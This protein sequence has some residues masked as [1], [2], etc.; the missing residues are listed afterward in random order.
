MTF[1]RIVLPY[2]FF[3]GVRDAM[4]CRASEVICEGP[5]DCLGGETRIFVV[6]RGPVP[7]EAL[8]QENRSVTV[9]S[10]DGPAIAEAPFIKGRARLYRVS[11]ADGRSF[12]AT[13]KHRVLTDQ[14]WAFVGSLQIGQCLPSDQQASTVASVDFVREDVY[15]DLHVPGPENYLAEGTFHHNT[16]KTLAFLVKLHTCAVKYP[17]AQISI[18]R[19]V[20]SD[21]TGSVMKTWDRDIMPYA[22]GVEAY[23]GKNPSWYD[24]PNGSRLWLGGLDKPG[25]TLSAERDIVYVNQCEQLS[26]V[27][28]EYLIRVTSGRG[29]VMPY[30]QVCGDCN[31]GSS[32]HWI[33]GRADVARFR[34]SHRDNPLLYNR[35]GTLTEAGIKRIGALKRL[36]GSRRQRLLLGLWA[37]P[38]GAIYSAYEE[39]HHKVKAFP[40]PKHWPRFVGVDPFGAQIGAVWLAWDVENNVINVYREYLE[41]F[42]V[43]TPQHVSGVLKASGYTARGIPTGEAE[44]IYAWVGGGPSERQWRTDWAGAGIPLLESP[45]HGVWEGID[46]ISAL[47]RDFKLVIHDSCPNLISE[48][49]SYS[50]VIVSG[51]PTESIADKDTYHL[52]DAL[53][54]IISWLTQPLTKTE[55]V[56]QLPRL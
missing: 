21:L 32:T 2:S 31:P 4:M 22:P 47:L 54:Y 28:W 18:L 10:T 44:P 41:P 15:Y 55:V 45:I 11:T 53:R 8:Y 12:V 16:G 25:K 52:C 26:M 49:G 50:R 29:A 1:K 30:T 40:I 34:T 48:I 19:K 51:V 33:L 39:E 43:T 42:G 23:G 37:P 5:A 17:K 35:D 13:Q 38:E 14:G 46:R 24:Y 56:I 6:G 27:D 7:V 36:T 20:Q 9:M 3:G